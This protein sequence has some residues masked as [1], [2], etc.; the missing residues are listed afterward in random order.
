MTPESSERSHT[1]TP[2]RT[3]SSSPMNFGMLVDPSHPLLLQSPTP[4]PKRTID[5]Q[6]NNFDAPMDIFHNHAT[7]SGGGGFDDDLSLAEFDPRPLRPNM[8]TNGGDMDD[9]DLSLAEFGPLGF[10]PFAL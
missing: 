1:M 5:L 6:N 3:G 2:P 8:N 10:D 4:P 9:D 7:N